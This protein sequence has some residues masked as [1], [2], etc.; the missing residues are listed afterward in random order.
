MTT[1]SHPYNEDDLTHRYNRKKL[2]LANKDL[3][4]STLPCK[5]G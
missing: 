4:L 3:Y 2:N 1:D 5:S